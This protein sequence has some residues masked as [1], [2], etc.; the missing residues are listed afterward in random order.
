MLGCALARPVC[1][2]DVNQVELAGKPVGLPQQ[3]GGVLARLSH[4]ADAFLRPA[5][6][7]P[8]HGGEFSLALV[9]LV[10]MS[11]VRGICLR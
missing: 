2:L 8:H 3:C 6:L 4:D 11:R 1:G 10:S 5:L 9:H 7:G